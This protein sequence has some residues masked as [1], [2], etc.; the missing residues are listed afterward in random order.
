L[1]Y[2]QEHLL[3]YVLVIAPLALIHALV[4]LSLSRESSP[5]PVS[6][7]LVRTQPAKTMVKDGTTG[8]P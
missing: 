4:L 8:K 3:K 1:K 6:L 7:R 5:Q 2:Q